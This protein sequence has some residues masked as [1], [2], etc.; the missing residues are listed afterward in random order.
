MKDSNLLTKAE[1]HRLKAVASDEEWDKAYDSIHEAHGGA[2]PAD[3]WEEVIQS[4]FAERVMEK[5]GAI[6]NASFQRVAKNKHVE[7]PNN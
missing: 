2:L 1:L 4:G 5:Y 3:W 6:S 7:D